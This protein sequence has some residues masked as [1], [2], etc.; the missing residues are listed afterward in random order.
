MAVEW[1]ILPKY[2]AISAIRLSGG[3]WDRVI[4]GLAAIQH[5]V[6]GRWQLLDLGMTRHEI[7]DRVKRGTLHHIR[8][9][10]YAAGS[11][12]LGLLG[13][14]MAAVLACGPGAL[15]SHLSCA[16][17]RGLLVDSRAVIDVIALNRR[18]RSTAG[19]K[20]HS[21]VLH[22]DDIDEVEGIPCTSLARTLLDIAG[23]VPERRLMA[24]YREAER[25]RVLDLNQVRAALARG[26]RPRGAVNLR[27]VIAAFDP[28]TLGTES[29]TEIR[30]YEI[31]R[32]HG[33]PLPRSNV[34]IEVEGHSYRP[35]LSWP[36]G[37]LIVEGDGAAT[38]SS[39][40]DRHRD[41]GREL[42]LKRAGWLVRR[43]T[44]HQVTYE[45]E[46]V[47]REIRRLLA[48]RRALAA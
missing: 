19:I 6:V 40:R 48:A 5:N 33:I 20:A 42:R 29:D 14:F 31:C 15:L 1:T 45:P 2:A 18:G 44:W 23:R 24:A 9:G 25:R 46:Y 7:A 41:L 34:P 8:D 4:A 21:C 38:H 36:D 30:I 35:D 3:P 37:R 11:P 17:L 32:D 28:E 22:P 47:A 16:E 13:H 26:G 12:M 27:S 39:S 43:F 10:V